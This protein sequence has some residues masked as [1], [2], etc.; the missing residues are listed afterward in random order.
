MYQLTKV[1]PEVLSKVQV[2][3]QDKILELTGSKLEPTK[4]FEIIKNETKDFKEAN[5]KAK[6]A[7]QL[8]MELL[9]LNGISVN[10]AAGNAGGKI[11]LR[12]QERARA[13]ELLELEL[14]L[15]A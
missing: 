10:G 8:F 9:K 12:E 3:N 11:R 4:A 13:I 5:E 7:D 2:K 6:Q 1:K 15:A 14:E